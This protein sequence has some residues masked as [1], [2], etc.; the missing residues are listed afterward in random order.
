MI[1]NNQGFMLAEVVIVSTVIVTTLVVL[2]ASSSKLSILY[3]ERSRYYNIDG[4][5]AIKS[6]VNDLLGEDKL[7]NILSSENFTNS[8]YIYLIK[9]NNCNTDIFNSDSMCTSLKN[10]YNI[11]NMVITKANNIY[12]KESEGEDK[13]LGVEDNT[14][15]MN[16]TFKDYLKYLS[17]YYADTYD[18]EYLV[19]LEYGTNNDK[20]YYSNLRL[21]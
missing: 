16:E 5:Y 4:I 21:R 17:N 14:L 15:E 9:N 10:L 2:Y 6:M 8:D 18:F 7:N 1:K 12:L 11:K 3:D 19:I 20:L 13:F